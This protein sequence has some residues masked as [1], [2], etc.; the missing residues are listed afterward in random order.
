MEGL[1]PA[2]LSAP[3]PKSGVSTNFT[4]SAKIIISKSEALLLSARFGSA[5]IKLFF[6][7]QNVIVKFTFT[8]SE[9]EA[10]A[11]YRL[12]PEYEESKYLHLTPKPTANEQDNLPEVTPF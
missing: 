9:M 2:H 7:E 4:T 6:T 8:A 3:D 12:Y 5:K 1:E 10:Y 11:H